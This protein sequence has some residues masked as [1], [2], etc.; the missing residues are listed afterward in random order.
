MS[1]PLHINALLSGYTVL[2][3]LKV[4]GSTVRMI[5]GF[6]PVADFIYG[7]YYLQ[8]LLAHDA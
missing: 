4:C 1:F 2:D 8:E 5:I 6:Y 7:G 3:Q